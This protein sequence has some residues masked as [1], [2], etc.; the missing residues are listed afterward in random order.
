MNNPIEAPTPMQGEY[1]QTLTQ[2]LQAEAAIRAA[3]LEGSFG[4]GQADRYSDLDIHLLLMPE[5]VERFRTGAEAWLNEIR[6]LVLYK[7]MFDGRMINALTVD[8]LRL[9]IWLHNDASKSIDPAKARVLLAQPDALSFDAAAPAADPAAVAARLE[10]LIQEFWRCISLLPAGVGRSE[11]IIGV[12]GLGIEINLLTDILLS[13]YG[14]VRDR[15]VKH[16]NNYL[17]GDSR[18]QL[19]AALSMNGLTTAEMAKAHLALAH[20]MQQ[21]GPDIAHRHGFAYPAAL[22]TAVL[23]YVHAELTP[24]GLNH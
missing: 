21:V 1:L 7:L 19:E 22:E 2:K 5:Q 9:D 4:R 17:P 20:I 15:G 12:F 14:I 18:Q 13:G 3:W 10:G 11:L 8:G 6:P 16:L 23:D 24:L